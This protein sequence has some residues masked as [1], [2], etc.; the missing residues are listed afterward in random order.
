MDGGLVADNEL[1]IA[2][3]GRHSGH[4]KPSAQPLLDQSPPVRPACSTS[5]PQRSPRP[6][7]LAIAFPG[8]RFPSGV[9]LATA[10]CHACFWIPGHLERHRTVRLE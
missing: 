6:N 5:R 3:N 1:V 8:G 4:R 2:R 7:S 10:H 9:R